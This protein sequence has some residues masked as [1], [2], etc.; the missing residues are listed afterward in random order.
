MDAEEIPASIEA[1][2]QA[3]WGLRSLPVDAGVLH[4][5]A[6]WLDRGP[7]GDTRRVIR[8]TPSSPK[9]ETDAFLL[10]LARARADVILTTGKILR[11]EPELEYSLP[12]RW[13]DAMGR[14]RAEQMGREE[15]PTLAVLTSGRDLD[16]EHPALHG[17]ADPVVLT[18]DNAACAV[19]S[20]LGSAVRVIGLKSPGPRS[21]IDW[22]RSRGA[23][24][25]TI[26][27]GPRTARALYA[28]PLAVDELW[29]SEYLETNLPPALRGEPLFEGVEVDSHLRPAGGPTLLSQASGRWRFQRFVR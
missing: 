22:A 19:R 25:I 13:R 1:R 23:T 7:Q 10:N 9:S 11:D 24:T 5:V 21:A 29:L 14:W 17:W 15:P 2:L 18:S 4:V 16:P 12:E 8:I 28:A 27:A 6:T 20:R 26:E 3:L